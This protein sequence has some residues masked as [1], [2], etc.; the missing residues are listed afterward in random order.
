[1][2]VTAKAR[3]SV[4]VISFVFE[5]ADA[6]PLATPLPGQFIVLRL[7]PSRSELARR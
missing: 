7:Q 1:M 4:D 3:E 2:R 5:P 6:L